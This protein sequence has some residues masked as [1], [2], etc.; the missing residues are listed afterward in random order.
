MYVRSCNQEFTGQERSRCKAQKDPCS[1]G[2]WRLLH[3]PLILRNNPPELAPFLPVRLASGLP[4][5][6]GPFP[7][8]S[9]DES[10]NHSYIQ[11]FMDVAA[12]CQTILTALNIVR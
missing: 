12:S 10:D 3:I 6:V 5:F 9:L 4:G 8:T 2:A 1:S 11:L 7:S